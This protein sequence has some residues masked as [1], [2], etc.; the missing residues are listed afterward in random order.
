MG[1]FCLHILNPGHGDGIKL[2]YQ[3]P[4]CALGIYIE[5]L[6]CAG[7]A[8]AEKKQGREMNQRELLRLQA[9]CFVMFLFLFCFI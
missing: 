9:F 5:G 4:V 6:L 3:L 2:S 1:G 8:S 7:T